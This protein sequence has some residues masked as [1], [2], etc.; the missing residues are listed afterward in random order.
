M[1]EIFAVLGFY[2]V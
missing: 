2:A 1:F